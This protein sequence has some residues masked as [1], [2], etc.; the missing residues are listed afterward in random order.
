VGRNPEKDAL[1]L[2]VVPSKNDGK[3]LYTLSVKDVPVEAFGSITVYNAE[4][5]FRKNPYDAYTLNNI[6]AAK[7]ADGSVAIQFRWL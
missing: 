3:T 6:T 5:Y 1:Y 2:T 7:G 4:G